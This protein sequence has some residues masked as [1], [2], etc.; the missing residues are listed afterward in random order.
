MTIINTRTSNIST[1]TNTVIGKNDTCKP[2]S[3]ED[4]T[5]F[6]DNAQRLSPIDMGNVLTILDKECPTSLY[7]NVHNNEVLINA[8]LI[9]G[10]AFY[11]V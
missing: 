1:K 8:D 3:V 2:P 4:L 5:I 10:A 9:N 7:K 6:A 11:K